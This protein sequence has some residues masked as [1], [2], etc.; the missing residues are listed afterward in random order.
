MLRIRSI[1]VLVKK[2]EFRDN[3]RANAGRQPIDA[4]NNTLIDLFSAQNIRIEVV[5]SRNEVDG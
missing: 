2:G 4:A 3:F 5:K 1:S